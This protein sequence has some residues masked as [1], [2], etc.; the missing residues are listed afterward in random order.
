MIVALE[1]EYFGITSNG[2]LKAEKNQCPDPKVWGHRKYFINSDDRVMITRVPCATGS[3]LDGTKCTLNSVMYLANIQQEK[4]KLS[5]RHGILDFVLSLEAR[6]RE[7][8]I[9]MPKWN[10][11][12][13]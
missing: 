7:G 9:G 11:K 13:Q 1:L 6:I 3:A 4:S 10:S 8:T 12:D 2:I 5:C